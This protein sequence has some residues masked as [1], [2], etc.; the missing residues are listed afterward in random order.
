VR[1][2]GLGCAPIR[3][4]GAVGLRGDNDQFRFDDFTVTSAAAG[5]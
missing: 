5:S 1:D 4:P 3:Q 2:R